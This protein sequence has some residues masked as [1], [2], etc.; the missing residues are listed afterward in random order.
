[1]PYESEIPQSFRTTYR[2]SVEFLLE[3]S[4][5]KL[6]PCVMDMDGSGDLHKLTDQLEDVNPMTKTGRNAKTEYVEVGHDGRW[7]AQPDPLVFATM[8]DNEDQLASGIDL[9]GNYATAGARAIARGTDDTIIGSIYGTAQTGDKGTVLTSFDTGNVVPVNEGSTSNTNLTVAK[10]RAAW[11][12][13]TANFV[14]LDMDELWMAV[15]ASQAASLM[16]EIEA[17]NRDYGAT[18][19]EIRDGKLRK[20]FGW[21][22]VHIELGNPRFS[23]ASLTVDGSGYRKVP[24]WAKSGMAAV[25]WER[26]FTSIDRLP[27]NHYSA[28]VYARR[29]IAATRLQEGKVGYILCNEG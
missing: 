12:I 15:T 16:A 2:D 24:F 17:V 18:G 21:N 8:V 23:N 5:S 22:F 10:L 1:M 27:G 9:S 20:L 7:V 26:L 19:E 11:E 29:A 13:L 3:Q 6:L 28:Q 25:F 4:D 14:D